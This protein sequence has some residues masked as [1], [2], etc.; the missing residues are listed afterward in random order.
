MVG[1]NGTLETTRI[2]NQ[3]VSSSRISRVNGRSI[4]TM[5]K[6]KIITLIRTNNR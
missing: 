2:N 3:E 6:F 5:L 1:S 4:M